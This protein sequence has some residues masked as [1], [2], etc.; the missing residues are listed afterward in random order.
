MCLHCHPLWSTSLQKFPLSPSIIQL[1]HQPNHLHLT[2]YQFSGLYRLLHSTCILPD[3]ILA[4]ILTCSRSNLTW[5]PLQR[6]LFSR[7]NVTCFK[8]RGPRRHQS[9]TNRSI[10]RLG[11]ECH[12]SADSTAHKHHNPANSTSGSA[13]ARSIPRGQRRVGSRS[14]IVTASHCQL[15]F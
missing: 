15:R 1:T 10:S 11:V 14:A 6:H 9:K 3:C 13:T 12:G 4:N 2:L 7:S 8:T 5:S